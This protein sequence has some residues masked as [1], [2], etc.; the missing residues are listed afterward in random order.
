LHHKRAGKRHPLLLPARQFGRCAVGKALKA[1]GCKPFAHLRV[2]PGLAP[3]PQAEGHVFI[4]RQMRKQRVGLK[5]QPHIAPRGGHARHI[6]PVQN[7]AAGI[8][9]QQARDGAHRGGLAAARRAKKA[10]QF[11]LCDPEAE[12]GHG[13]GAAIGQAQIFQKDKVRHSATI[14]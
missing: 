11:A 13:N 2:Q 14:R 9:H 3:Q 12:V 8:G 4:D 5:H 6:P 1:D 10:D 7:D